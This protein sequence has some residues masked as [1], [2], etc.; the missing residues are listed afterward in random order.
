[1]SEKLLEQ[2]TYSNFVQILKH[3]TAELYAEN[4]LQW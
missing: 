1:M 4:G 2:K 3:D